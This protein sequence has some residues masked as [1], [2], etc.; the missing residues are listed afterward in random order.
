MAMAEPEGAVVMASANLSTQNTQ[1][2]AR[3]GVAIL[4]A[5]AVLWRQHGIAFSRS[6]EQIF[7]HAVLSRVE[8]EIAAASGIELRVRAAFHDFPL[9]HHHDL[10]CAA[11]SRKAMRDDKRSASLHQVRKALLNHVFG[12]GVEA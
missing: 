7:L 11:D 3:L 10:V 2:V 12:F 5:C 9:F 1:G 4:F 8:V 6:Q